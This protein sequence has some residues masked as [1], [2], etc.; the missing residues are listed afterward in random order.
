VISAVVETRRRALIS[1][2]KMLCQ[3]SYVM[4]PIFSCSGCGCLRIRQSAICL[5][6]LTINIH[7]KN[8]DSVEVFRDKKWKKPLENKSKVSGLDIGISGRSKQ[9]QSEA[10]VKSVELK[11]ASGEKKKNP[12]KKNAQKVTGPL[13]PRS[14]SMFRVEFFIEN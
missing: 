10:P 4:Q 3:D 12:A 7:Y 6:H 9:R 8:S 1:R 2:K 11:I 13:A 5:K 14:I